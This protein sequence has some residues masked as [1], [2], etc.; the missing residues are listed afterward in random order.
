MTNECL[1]ANEN[2]YKYISTIVK[3]KYEAD[4]YL[5]IFQCYKEDNFMKENSYK[6]YVRKILY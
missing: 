5:F 2:N 1:I 4:F 6:T 3:S